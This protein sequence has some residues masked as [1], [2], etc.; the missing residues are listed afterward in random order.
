MAAG[1]FPLAIEGQDAA[2]PVDDVGEDVSRRVRENG[3]EGIS[4]SQDE[5]LLG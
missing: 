2:V 4:A 1:E 5:C 3:K